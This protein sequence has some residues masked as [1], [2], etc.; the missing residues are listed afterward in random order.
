MTVQAAAGRPHPILHAFGIHSFARAV[1][2]L[3]A[4]TTMLMALFTFLNVKADGNSKRFDA[5]S[6]RLSIEALTLATNGKTQVS[7]DWGTAYRTWKELDT[8]AQS[9]EKARDLPETE[10]LKEL[11]NAVRNESKLLADRYFPK[12]DGAPGAASAPDLALYESE[13]Y[14]QREQ[15]LSEE[16]INLAEIKS[17]WDGQVNHYITVLAFLSAAL[18]IAGLALTVPRR[19]GGLLVGLSIAM[20]IGGSLYGANA[21]ATRNRV[22]RPRRWT[23]MPKARL[24]FTLQRQARTPTNV[25]STTT[26]RYRSSATRCSFTTATPTP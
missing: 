4:T 7:F 3:L 19:V 22:S 11:R 24:R 20:I 17:F 21:I 6:H 9:A 25:S 12:S 1:A 13:L 10:R 8:A 26:W 2:M 14:F 23:P 15:R 16:A 5:T 18:F